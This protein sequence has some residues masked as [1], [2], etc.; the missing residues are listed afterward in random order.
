M[1]PLELFHLLPV[2]YQGISQL[3]LLSA[4]DR[5]APLG[6]GKRSSLKMKS[7]LSNIAQ[8]I[9][10]DFDTLAEADRNSLLREL[11]GMLYGLPFVFVALIWLIVGTDLNVLREQWLVLLLLLGLSVLAGRLSFFQITISPNGN[12][13]YNGSSLEIVIVISA[14]LLFGP[15]AVWIPFLGRLIDF[16]IDQP[17]SPSRLQQWN[18]IRNL[19]FNLG[20]S[21]IVLLLAL[22]LYQKLG[23]QYPLS[24]LT[25]E[26]AWPALLAVLFWLPLEGLFMLSYGLLV[27]RFQLAS[28]HQLDNRIGF[29]KRM[30]LFF[31]VANSP[32]FF[33]I[34]AAV[35]YVQLGLFAYLFFIGG[36]L[37]T[38]LL[39]RRLSQ[40]AL[41]SQQRSREVMQLEQLGRA[42][43]AAPIDAST[44][45]Q[46]LA[47]HVPRMFG[48]HQAEIGLHSGATLLHLPEDRPPMNPEIWD[49]LESNPMPI[50]F[51][52]GEK[53]PWS[54]RATIHPLY[55]SPILST[56]RA[57]PLGGVCLTLNRSYF[58]A[59]PLDLE[60]ALQV[61]AAQIATALH[62]ADEQIQTLAHQKMVQELDFAW[63]IQTSFLPDTLPQIEGWQ[64][65]AILKPCKE[66]S[67][68]FYDVI[69]LPNGRLGILIADVTDKGMGA[70]LFMALSHT[71]IRT[72]AF[73]HQNQPDVVLQATNK[74]ILSDTHNDMFVT[75]FYGILDLDTGLLTYANAGHNPPYLFKAKYPD[76]SRESVKS[77]GLRN[78]GMPLGILDEASWEAEAIVLDHGDTLI[79][80]TDGVTEA[81][82]QKG[83]LFGDYRLIKATQ[84]NF[85]ATAA[86]IQDAVLATVDQFSDTDAQCDDETLVI[87]KRQ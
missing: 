2:Y 85:S 32:A 22:L 1:P 19:T 64:L 71:L 43:M 21:I 87:V 56:E 73:E 72:Y 82:N 45:P 54:K 28:P 7:F 57:E 20:P 39:A 65:A 51:A 29:G 76:R 48:Y 3:K 30:Y 6:V 14:M 47:S 50:Y 25:L 12:Y 31:L 44:L 42:I 15:T 34:I 49:W 17:Q 11:F 59:T 86:A 5:H 38:S 75:V 18:R 23:G 68:D 41:L 37:L 46:I 9:W 77:Q 80:Y 61:L 24:E 74:R 79:M 16:G 78:T 69:P 83:E 70:A 35:I 33:G 55:L 60:P 52:P 8:K 4:C 40:Q 66:T 81:Q 84:D 62:R 10:P 27:T 63:Q 36:V 67:G 58:E 53:P 13:D 26:T